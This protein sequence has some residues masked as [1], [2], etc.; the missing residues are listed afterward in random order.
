MRK[1]L[2]DLLLSPTN[3]LGAATVSV[4]VTAT[5]NYFFKRR[6]NRHKAAL[7]YEYEQKKASRELIARYKG[8]ILREAVQMTG[9]QRNLYS[10]W[11]NGWM[12]KTPSVGGDGYYFTSTVYRFLSLYTL[13]HEADSEAILLDTDIAQK[14]DYAFLKYLT[15]MRWVMTDVNLFDGLQYDSSKSSDHFFS[16]DLRVCTKPCWLEGKVVTYDKFRAEQFV[17]VSTLPILDFF[18][19]LQ[20]SENRYRWD[21][22]VALHLILAA[23]INK[24]G[25]DLQH[26]TNKDIR[27]IAEQVQH[28]VILE[29]LIAGLER[30]RLSRDSTIKNLIREMRKVIN[31]P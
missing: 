2:L 1:E 9:R 24:F 26:A 18:D 19:G 20:K 8:R 10:N 16:D 27:G 21:R 31:G 23:Y 3:L 6:E 30:H 7:D 25:Y 4:L 29:N 5:V 22:L 17:A 14:T 15:V 28:R 13:L 12:S 11:K